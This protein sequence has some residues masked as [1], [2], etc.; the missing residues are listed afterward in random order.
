M[1]EK[2]PANQR[3]DEDLTTQQAEE[4]RLRDPGL[5]T[6]ASTVNQRLINKDGT[7]NIRRTGSYWRL[8]HPYQLLISM[9]WWKF[10]LV[11]FASY[12][13]IN[14]CFALVYLTV[15]VQTLSGAPQTGWLQQF[16]HAFFFSVQTIT[17]V[18]YGTISPK[19]MIV[20]LIAS[21]EAMVGLLGF[22]MA[23]GLM[24]GR[25]S[26]ATANVAFSDNILIAPYGDVNGLM[27]R[28]GNR[29][30]NQLIELHIRVVLMYYEHT[31][32]G[33]VRRFYPLELER[34]SVALFPLT[35]TVVHPMDENSPLLRYG[36]EA[37][38]ASEA[39][40]MINLKGFDDTFSQV[41]H[42]RHSYLASEM[43]WG[44]KFTPA[45]FHDEDGMMVL[46][47]DEVGSFKKATLNA[48]PTYQGDLTTDPGNQLETK[49][50]P[51][52]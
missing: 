2:K 44:A 30:K 26:R 3:P 4:E 34:D 18:G 47:L 20:N 46:D 22:A 51:E 35:W 23:S 37:L 17:T 25:F 8:L 21:F 39:E 19:G 10:G 48:N 9:P 12:I 36:R 1:S 14:S 7:F 49:R 33:I 29:R 52:S 15:G 24:Y 6:I 38:E 45:F 5:G 50:Q 41:V 31:Q 13:L 27:F 40:I 32:T 16:S 42:L 28:I 11:V 43:I